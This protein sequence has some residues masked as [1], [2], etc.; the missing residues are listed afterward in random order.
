MSEPD[1]FGIRELS[2]AHNGRQ[3]SIKA[4]PLPDGWCIRVFENGMPI[5]PTTLTVSHEIVFD[6]KMQ[7]SHLDLVTSL[8]DGLRVG[9]ERGM[10]Q[11]LPSSN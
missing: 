5:S 1:E 2:F 3:L 7:H 10:E 8:M 6:A 9:V 4:A 11:L